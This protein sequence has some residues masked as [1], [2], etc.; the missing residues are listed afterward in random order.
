MKPGADKTA[1]KDAY[2]DDQINYVDNKEK[3]E[4]EKNADLENDA[5]DY[6]AD[7]NALDMANKQDR[8]PADT[9]AQDDDD[10][11]DGDYRAAGDNR[12][13]LAVG[14]AGNDMKFDGRDAYELKDDHR[15]DLLSTV[16]N[17]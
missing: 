13:D 11:E 1:G 16:L 15:A 9:E 2:N 3:G 12:A 10:D 6:H 14:D 8:E 7:R 4:S 17:F 5:G